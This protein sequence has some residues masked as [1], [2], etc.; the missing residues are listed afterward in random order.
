MRGTYVWREDHSMRR[1]IY[2]KGI[3][4]HSTHRK[5]SYSWEVVE[6]FGVL[7]DKLFANYIIHQVITR[8][9]FGSLIVKE[10][11]ISRLSDV[12]K[13]IPTESSAVCFRAISEL[14]TRVEEC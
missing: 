13:T 11:F 7:I 1:E 5:L 6:A 4:T 14:T 2:L 10:F 9:N 3:K 8:C 12:V